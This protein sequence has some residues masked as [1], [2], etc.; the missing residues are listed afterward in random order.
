[1]LQPDGKEAVGSEEVTLTLHDHFLAQFASEGGVG[2]K[3][4]RWTEP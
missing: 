3:T 2:M 1:M 4:R